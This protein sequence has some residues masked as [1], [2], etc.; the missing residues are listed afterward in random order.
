MMFSIPLLK[1][2]IYSAIFPL[3]YF[4]LYLGLGQIFMN[5]GLL[6][7]FP[8]FMVETDIMVVDISD[9]VTAVF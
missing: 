3:R 2:F 1:C 4:N 7:K 6:L 5:L 8:H 9:I